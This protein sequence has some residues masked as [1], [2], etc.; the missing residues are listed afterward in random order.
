MKVL[1][2]T[3]MY[4]S[5]ESPYYGIF[6]K[7][8][9]NAVSKV[10]PDVDY[11]VC[12]IDGRKGL[13][14]YLKSISAIHRL[15]DEN[16]YDLIHIH[17]GFAGL[18]LF[19]RLKKKIPVLV[20]L[21]GGDI[22]IEQK[23]YIQ[24]FTDKLILKR[25]DAAITLNDRMDSIVKKY[26]DNTF[27]IPCSVDTELFVPAVSEKETV[28]VKNIVFPSDRTRYVKN[29]PLFESVISVLKSKYGIDSRIFEIKNMSRTEI[30]NL[31]QKSDLMIM[32]SFSEGSPQVVKEAMSC[33][34]PVVSTNVGDVSV[35]LDNVAGSAVVSEMDAE[36]IA[37]AAY[38]SLGGH[39][40]GISGRDKIKQ[41]GLD[42]NSTAE[43]EYRV[44][45][46]LINN[47]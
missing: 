17:Y 2:V 22:Q 36:L 7:E 8:Q 27:I 47:R 37:E 12:F 39:F 45:S 34:L 25:A 13:K 31:L 40:S 44:Y 10:F 16:D 11:T 24:V 14:E 43:S 30:A 6:V 42:N 19:K 15:L 4:P 3:N 35:L 9:E 23:K 21:H 28:P 41:L 26:V 33:N 20:T 1:L 29:Y 46:H 38:K 5:E 18:F 32:T